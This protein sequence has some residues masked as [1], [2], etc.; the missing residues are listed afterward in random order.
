[1][2]KKGAAL[3]QVLLI[4]VILAGIAT[5]LLRASLSNTISARK[6]R[7]HVT[8]Q[9]VIESCMA[10]V[11]ALWSLKSEEAI[12]GDLQTRDT[13]PLMYC[14]THPSAGSKCSNAETEH[15]CDIPLAL[16]GSS[17]YL[18]RVKATI[19]RENSIAPVQVTYEI[20]EGSEYL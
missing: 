4:A 10:E 9:T 13:K 14:L 5:M 17:D 1:M 15:I 6:S 18:F 12:R 20:I 19:S 8:A 3:M 2:N 11:N 16:A 7:R